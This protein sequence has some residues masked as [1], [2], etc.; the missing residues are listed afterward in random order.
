MRHY[1]KFLLYFLIL[2]LF[3]SFSD[4]QETFEKAAVPTA[5]DRAK[6]STVRIVGGNLSGLGVGTGFFVDKDKIVTNVHVVSQP[7]LYFAKL[8]DKGPVWGIEGVTAFDIKNDLVVLKIAGEGTPLPLGKSDTV[9]IGE[10]VATVGFPDG[11]YSVTEGTIHSIWQKKQ[12]VSID[13][14]CYWWKQ[15][16][17]FTKQKRGGYRR[18]GCG[19]WCFQLCYSFGHTQNITR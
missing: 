17:P 7:G 2:G 6:E 16:W 8:I 14:R 15:R 13:N 18:D 3:L 4:A 5:T 19:S 10:L 12:M 1:T 9:Q 11:K